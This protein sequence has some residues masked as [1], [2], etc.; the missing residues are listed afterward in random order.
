MTTYYK[1]LLTEILRSTEGNQAALAAR[2]QVAQPTISGWMT[3]QHK[4]N[5]EQY[6][7]ITSLAKKLNIN[8]DAAP[9]W[10]SIEIDLDVRKRI[11]AERQEFEETPND[12][13]RRLLKID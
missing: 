12:V 6:L 3:G 7:A 4:P 11:E 1:W 10:T 13:L 5:V 8:C 9:V 2:L